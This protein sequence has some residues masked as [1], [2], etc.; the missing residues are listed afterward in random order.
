MLLHINNIQCGFVDPQERSV[1]C[2]FTKS[3]RWRDSIPNKNA[4][5][6][7]KFR[8]FHTNLRLARSVYPTNV[9]N[10][11][12]SH[13]LFTK[14]H[15]QDSLHTPAGVQTCEIA[16]KGAFLRATVRVMNIVYNLSP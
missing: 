16:V 3:A 10:I 5:N 14:Y 1:Y 4:Q 2:K 7:Q 13:E 12:Y 9:A 6:V 11:A 8:V 15:P